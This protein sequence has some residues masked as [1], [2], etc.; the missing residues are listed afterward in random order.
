[1]ARRSK[2]EIHGDDSLIFFPTIGHFDSAARRWHLAFHGWIF[3]PETNSLR[4]A[5]AVNMLRRWLGIERA[6]VEGE[7]FSERLWA[8]LV[9]NQP[10]KAVAVRIGND[11]FELTPSTSNGHIVDAL[12]LPPETVEAALLAQAVDD[13]ASNSNERWLLLDVMMPSGDPRRIRAALHLLGEQGMSVISDIDDTIKVTHVHDRAALLRQTFFRDFESVPGMA[14]LYRRWHAAGAAFHYVSRSPWQL[15]TP[16][17]EFVT[18]H[19]F[20]AGTFHMRH[21]RWKNASTLE[22][23]KDGSKKLAVIAEIFANLPQRQFVCVGDSGEHDPEV[24]AE[25]A[26]RHPTQVKAIYIRCVNGE[27]PRSARLVRTFAGLPDELWQGFNDP[28]ELSGELP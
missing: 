16:L 25:L 12:H 23:D 14:E 5:A 13:G 28:A 17:S 21:F 9:N 11:S 8:F 6:S 10:R 4:R 22:S 7:L 24:Y 20:P 1:M 27:E 26:R 3:K 19:G 2:I 15:Y 18:G